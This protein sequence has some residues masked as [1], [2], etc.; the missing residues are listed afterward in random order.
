MI[1]SIK[2]ILYRLLLRWKKGFKRLSPTILLR[3]SFPWQMEC[4]A[5]PTIRSLNWAVTAWINLI[6]VLLPHDISLNYSTNWI[7]SYKRYNQ[8]RFHK[9]LRKVYLFILCL[10]VT[11]YFWWQPGLQFSRPIFFPD[12]TEIFWAVD[13][14]SITVFQDLSLA[15]NRCQLLCYLIFF[16][17]LNFMSKIS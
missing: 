2:H 10:Q 17:C 6:R 14:D 12:V 11:A 4:S 16:S 9:L 15:W 3:T 1:K 8:L 13:I 7:S 5:S